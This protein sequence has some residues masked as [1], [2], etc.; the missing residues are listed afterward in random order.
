M[1]MKNVWR[2]ILLFSSLL[3][4][5]SC[6]TPVYKRETILVP[7]IPDMVGSSTILSQTRSWL[8]DALANIAE[9]NELVDCRFSLASRQNIAEYCSPNVGVNYMLTLRAIELTDRF[10]IIVEDPDVT[11]FFKAKESER[12]RSI[13]NELIMQLDARWPG[14]VKHSC[15]NGEKCMSIIE[16]SD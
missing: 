2:L 8:V 11:A 1:N 15:E 4:I 13:W 9:D 10:K 7:I 12:L 3:F 6:W 14:R 5:T 16:Y